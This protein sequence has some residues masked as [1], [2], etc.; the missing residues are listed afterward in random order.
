MSGGVSTPAIPYNPTPTT[1]RVP[2]EGSYLSVLPSAQRLSMGLGPNDINRIIGDTTN[3]AYQIWNGTRFTDMNNEF[4]DVR[5]Y[6]A[7]GDGYTNDT[8]ALKNALDSGC[9]NI[10]FP[11]G[12]TF[13]LDNPDGV[14]AAYSVNVPSGIVFK[15]DGVLSSTLLKTI[16]FNLLGDFGM[17]GSGTVSF[18]RG[19]QP[20]VFIFSSGTVWC[21]GM[22]FRGN[23]TA[24]WYWVGSDPGS[25]SVN[26]FSL[27]N[28]K[29]RDY[30]GRAYI[31]ESVAGSTHA[32]FSTLIESCELTDIYFF[33][34]ININNVTGTDRN[35][36]IVGNSI[37]HVFG[38]SGSDPNEGF[39]ISLAGQIANAFNPDSSLT[40]FIIAGNQI[41][42]CASGIHIEYCNKGLIVSNHIRDINA[43]YYPASPGEGGI[44]VYGSANWCA[45]GNRIEDVSGDTVNMWGIAA[46]G[47]FNAGYKQ[48]CRDFVISGNTLLNASMLLENEIQSSAIGSIPPYELTTNSLLNVENN[49][50]R[51]GIVEVYNTGQLNVRNNTITAPLSTSNFNVVSYSRNG[52]NIAT[53]TLVL[54]NSTLGMYYGDVISVQGVGSGFDT[55]FAVVTYVNQS[56]AVVSYSNTGAAV[57]TTACNGTLYVMKKALMIDCYYNAT[58]TAEFNAV[59]RLKVDLDNNIA[60]TVYGSS[61]FEIRNVLNNRWSNNIQIKCNGNNF[62]ING[63]AGSFQGLNGTNRAWWTSNVGLPTG[64]ELILGDSVWTNVSGAGAHKQYVITGQGYVGIVGDTYAVVSALNGT[65]KQTGATPW[66]ANPPG[67]SFGELVTLT[68]GGNS[69]VGLIQKMELVG[70]DS[71]MTLINPASGAALD[72][73][74][75][76]GPGTIAPY[77][78]ATFVQVS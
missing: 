57:G 5:M 12:Y 18:N 31:R 71:V 58:G 39:A 61:S 28:C 67:Y 49:S 2:G 37:S 10:Y 30:C 45:I 43:S 46:R 56:L 73:T 16:S 14:S 59:F 51:N 44:R 53:L 54:P 68:N 76:G 72:L 69:I 36:V 8:Q 23:S 41:E 1:W 74:T 9:K 64:T 40:G 24:P 48:S 75:V 47:G 25:G 26:S 50:L 21:R 35:V 65:I 62:G 52:A 32:I 13:L 70:A 7:V 3:R 27:V 77:Q 22:E 78:T 20:R 6:G 17:F 55:Q 34:G 38:T 66:L 60:E 4:V 33:S 15:V 29:F 63:V 42:K 19:T 11:R